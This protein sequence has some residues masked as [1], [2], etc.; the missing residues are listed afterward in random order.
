MI[1]A[2]IDWFMGCFAA[3]RIDERNRG[4]HGRVT[5]GVWRTVCDGIFRR[6]QIASGRWSRCPGDDELMRRKARTLVGLE[7]AVGE[8]VLLSHLEVGLHLGRIHVS[9]RAVLRAGRARN[10]IQVRPIHLT[11]PAD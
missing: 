3:G 8:S 1:E 7:H 2:W 10:R 5:S 9:K 11:L 4:A 6:K